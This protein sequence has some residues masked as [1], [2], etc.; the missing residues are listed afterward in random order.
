MNFRILVPLTYIFISPRFF[1]NFQ[2]Y[3]IFK[4]ISGLLMYLLHN[5]LRQIIGKANK[6]LQKQREANKGMHN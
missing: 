5:M 2:V 6:H 3:S 1:F 4:K